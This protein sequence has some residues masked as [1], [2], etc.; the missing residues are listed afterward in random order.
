MILH[1]DTER[2]SVLV[3][4]PDDCKRLC[5]VISGAG[6][7]DTALGPL[8][9]AD[10]DDAHLWIKVEALKRAAMPTHDVDWST[11]FDAMIE[12]AKSKGWIDTSKT[13]VRVHLS[14]Q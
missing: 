7:I 8:G 2:N 13:R 10:A 11:R 6:N 3:G 9:S 5:A 4:E 14:R 12:Y 1:I